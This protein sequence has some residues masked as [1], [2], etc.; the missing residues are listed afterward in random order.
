M[1][2]VDEQNDVLV[3]RDLVDDRLEALLELA[4]VFRTSDDGG[5]VERQDAVT[6]ERVGALPPRDQLRQPLD[7]RRLADAGL[8]DQ[9]RIVFLAA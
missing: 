3:L 6:L 4:A 9:H 2:L 1:Q 5:H 8:P 7:D